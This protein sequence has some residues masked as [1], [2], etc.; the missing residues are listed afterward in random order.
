MELKP[1]AEQ[2]FETLIV[3]DAVA[4]VLSM[5]KVLEPEEVSVL[6]ALGRVLAEDVVSDINVPPFNNSAM[7]GFAIRVDDIKGACH[8][9]PVE[10]EVIELIAAGDAPQK[11]VGPGQCARI[12]TGA[13]LPKGADSVIKIEQTTAYEGGGKVGDKVGI[14]ENVSL[15]SHVRPQGEDA[16]AGKPIL[17][18]GDVVDVAAVGLMA[19]TGNETVKVYRRPKVGIIAT[20]SELVNITDK[21]GP[22]KIRNSNSYTNAAQVKEAGGIPVIYPIVEDTYEA[23]VAAFKKAAEECD[24]IITSGGVSV[25]DFDFVRPAIEALGEIKFCKVHMRPGNPQ[26]MGTIGDAV[27]FGLPG[28]PSSCFVGFEVFMRPMIRKMQGF[29]ETHRPIIRAVLE[30][31]QKKRQERRYYNRGRVYQDENGKWIAHAG[32]NQNSALLTTVHESNAF[33]ILPEGVGDIPAGT[34]VDCWMF[35]LPEAF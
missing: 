15:G 32:A 7:D 11:E 10:L 4:Q 29:K 30:N 3:E 16:Q 24:L 27:L 8:Q 26:T 22:G 34:E 25:G 31:D 2:E 14:R 6:D 13:A 20:G 12:M 18:K 33:V 9:K 21:P 35:H 23:T 5:G 1:L 28:N 19:A 17:K